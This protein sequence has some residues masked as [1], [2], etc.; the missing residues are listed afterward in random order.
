MQQT[1]EK[2]EVDLRQTRHRLALGLDSMD[3]EG[4][5]LTGDG[6]DEYLVRK[7]LEFARDNGPKT[8]DVDKTIEAL[9]TAGRV[10][11]VARLVRLNILRIPANGVALYDTSGVAEE[12]VVRWRLINHQPQ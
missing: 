7:S 2:Y 11:Q 3:W 5:T 12:H 10:H 9:R 8:I 4:H 6:E 1:K